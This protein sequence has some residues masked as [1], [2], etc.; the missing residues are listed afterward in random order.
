MFF[1]FFFVFLWL[2][3][4]I[5]L[6]LAISGSVLCAGTV[7]KPHTNFAAISRCGDLQ[8]FSARFTIEVGG[9]YSIWGFAPRPDPLV[10]SLPERRGRMK[11]SYARQA[12]GQNFERRLR[13][14]GI[15]DFHRGGLNLIERASDGK[16]G[17]YERYAKGSDALTGQLRVTHKQQDNY[18]ARGIKLSLDGASLTTLRNG[19]DIVVEVEPGRCTGCL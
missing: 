15:R 6:Q 19:E 16:E 10:W 3:P 4:Y 17:N 18:L 14:E 7:A 13:G 11:S 2:K 8:F 9:N 12:F 1:V 5:H